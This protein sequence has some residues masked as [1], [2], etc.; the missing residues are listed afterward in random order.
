VARFAV[1]LL[2]VAAFTL[3]AAC[4]PR[5]TAKPSATAKPTSYNLKGVLTAP[6]CQGGYNISN[7]DVTVR[8]EK[9]EVIATT[10]TVVPPTSAEAVSVRDEARWTDLGNQ[11]D[12]IQREKT[13]IQS[14]YPFQGTDSFG[15]PY[16]SSTGGLPPPGS[17]DA[18]RLAQL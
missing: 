2:S 8:N 15:K 12:A 13:Q 5:G 10:T 11:I 16:Q 7:A 17:A 6:E 3:S 1:S 18:D 4:G 14:K 9:N